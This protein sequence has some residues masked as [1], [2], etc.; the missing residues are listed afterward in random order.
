MGK[1]C[2]YVQ[3]LFNGKGM[4]CVLGNQGFDLLLVVEI[5]AKEAVS[6]V[7]NGSQ[8]DLRALFDLPAVPEL[9]LLTVF[10][11]IAPL[12]LVTLC[13]E[14]VF[15][16]DSD[17]DHRFE[18]GVC[19]I[20]VGDGISAGFSCVEHPVFVAADRA[21]HAVFHAAAKSFEAVADLSEHGDLRK[22]SPDFTVDIDPVFRLQ[23]SVFVRVEA[24][25]AEVIELDLGNRAS[26]QRGQMN[27]AG[28]LAYGD[29]IFGIGGKQ[30]VRIVAHAVG[31]GEPA[32]EVIA[33]FGF[34]F[35]GNACA[36]RQIIDIEP[37][38][39][40]NARTDKL[41]RAVAFDSRADGERIVESCIN[42]CILGYGEFVNLFG[43]NQ[44]GVFARSVV[45]ADE[46]EVNGF[47]ACRNPDLGSFRDLKLQLLFGRRIAFCR[48]VVKISV[49]PCDDL[50]GHLAFF[51]KPRVNIGIVGD[52]EGFGRV[53]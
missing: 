35:N 46:P 21:F 16:H 45:P 14:A 8:R 32:Y 15:L 34:H 38:L 19:K 30:G 20:G 18:C 40:G 3:V 53:R 10:G 5:P 47:S 22:R 51:G 7:R 49:F 36:V 1:F 29:G 2:E 28:L 37:V 17:R 23:I 11:D 48:K 52:G 43:G 25:I 33:R 42:G 31:G 39:V 41:A 13:K 50:Q 6:L 26:E 4:R 24:E 27:I 12:I 9:D 44:R